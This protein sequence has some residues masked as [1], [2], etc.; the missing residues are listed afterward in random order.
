M[1]KQRTKEIYKTAFELTCNILK[2]SSNFY[3]NLKEEQMYERM[4]Q[5]AEEIIET[6]N[7][8]VKEHEKTK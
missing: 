7:K 5:M 4:L 2:S 1:K 6:V 8:G 3:D